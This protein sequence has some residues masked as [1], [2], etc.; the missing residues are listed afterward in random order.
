MAQRLQSTVDSELYV[1][2]PADQFYNRLMVYV[3]NPSF[4]LYFLT[5]PHTALYLVV[6]YC[7]KPHT[8]S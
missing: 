5:I 4:T 8:L 1:N 3:Y 6:R 7:S 2:L